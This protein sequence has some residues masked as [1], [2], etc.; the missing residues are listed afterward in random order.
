MPQCVQY[1]EAQLPE[2]QLFSVTERLKKVGRARRLMQAQ[3]GPMQG[4]QA[5][6]SGET[7]CMDMRLDDEAQPKPTLA[8][9]RI[10]RL[11]IASR[12]DDGRLEC[13]ARSD[14]LGGI[15]APFVENLL[16]IHVRP[17]SLFAPATPPELFSHD[18]V[19]LWPP[20]HSALCGHLKFSQRNAS[21]IATVTP[22][23]RSPLIIPNP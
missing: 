2:L 9:Q 12:V 13:L 21:T 20:S 4:G 22:S 18:R 1:A 3:L 16:E 19:T 10:V 5:A 17:S 6:G 14:H 8:K 15:P 7:V 11:R 23:L